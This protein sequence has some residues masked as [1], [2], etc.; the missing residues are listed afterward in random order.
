MYKCYGLR[1]MTVAFAMAHD[2]RCE[3]RAVLEPCDWRV[4]SIATPPKLVGATLCFN[5]AGKA[6]HVSGDNT[7]VHTMWQPHA[8]NPI[9]QVNDDLS[10]IPTDQHPKIAGLLFVHVL[11]SSPPSMAFFPSLLPPHLLCTTTAPSPH[12]H[13]L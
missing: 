6:K 8:M 7:F 5:R 4:A 9:P 13:A 2:T 11:S 10:R 3:G 12:T 1:T